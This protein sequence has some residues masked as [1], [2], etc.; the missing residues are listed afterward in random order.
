MEKL[1]PDRTADL[2]KPTLIPSQDKMPLDDECEQYS[3]L[4]N[5][6]VD[7]N[8]RVIHVAALHKLDL[9]PIVNEPTINSDLQYLVPTFTAG[10]PPLV[11]TPKLT[12]LGRL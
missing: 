5:K 11:N 12:Q 10:Q 3:E 4:T 8:I 7:E 2:H 1:F 9:Y 6:L